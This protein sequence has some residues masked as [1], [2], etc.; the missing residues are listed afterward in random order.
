LAPTHVEARYKRVRDFGNE[1]QGP[2]FP[3]QREGRQLSLCPSLGVLLAE[4][5]QMSHSC[6]ESMPK[7]V[8]PRPTESVS[9]FWK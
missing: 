5:F 2:Q 6:S 1:V 4:I 8:H 9:G 7:E 3:T